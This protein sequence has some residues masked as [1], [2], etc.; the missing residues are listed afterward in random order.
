MVKLG[1][2][3]DT[4]VEDLETSQKV[5]DL[6][7]ELKRVF[8]DVDEIIHAGDVCDEDFLQKLREIAPTHCVKY[9]EVREIH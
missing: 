8:K 2:I 5:E 6:L 7:R 9:R 1:I 3:S 4:H